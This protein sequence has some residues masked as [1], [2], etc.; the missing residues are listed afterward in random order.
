MRKFILAILMAVPVLL[1][2]THS[3]RAAATG[4]VTALTSNQANTV[5]AGAAVPIFKIN[6]NAS[7]GENLD[8]VGVALSSATSSTAA[9]ATSSFTALALYRD[10]AAPLGTFNPNDTLLG[11]TTVTSVTATTTL[12]LA[13]TTPATG[14]FFLVAITSNAWTDSGA[15]ETAGRVPQE[16]TANLD[17][18]TASGTPATLSGTLATQPFVADIHSQTP[19]VS[20]LGVN[21]NNSNQY[22]IFD[23]NGNGGVGEL[24]TLNVYA[25]SSPGAAPVATTSVGPGGHVSVNLG[26]TYYPSLWLDATDLAGNATSSQAQFTLPALPTVTSLKAFTDRIIFTASENL[27]GQQA[28]NCSNYSITQNGVTSTLSCGQPGSPFVNFM[29]NQVVIQGLNLTAGSSIGFS[30]SGIRDIASDQFAL[31]YATSSVTVLQAQTPTVSALSPNSGTAGVTS[32][33]I[34]GSNFGTST[35]SVLFSGGFDQNTGPLPPVAATSVTSW[36]DT[37]ITAVVPSGA[38]GGPVQIVTSDGMMSDPSQNTY[39]D[40]KGSIYL[41]LSLGTPS[42][43]IATST[44]MTFVMF[45]SSNNMHV[46]SDGNGATFDNSTKIYTIANV[47]SQGFVWAFDAGGADL[48]APGQPISPNTSTSSPQVLTLATS[49]P[50]SVSGTITLGGSSCANQYIGVMALPQGT[51][52]NAGGVQPAFF[53]TNGSCQATYSLALPDAGTY[54]V[55]THLPPQSTMTGVL[56]P[57]GQAITV[58]GGTPTATANF[59]FSTAA[60]SIYGKIVGADGQALPAAKYSNMMVYAYQPIK[61]GQGAVAQPDSNGYFRVYASTGAYKVTVGG[62][63]MPNGPET[64]VLVDSSASFAANAT[65]TVV[66]ITMAPPSSYIEGYVKDASGNGLASVDVFSYCS[67]GP[68]GGH[69][70][71]DNQG[72]YKMYVPPCANYHINGFSSTYGQLTEQSNIAIANGS[73]SATVNFTVN[74]SNFV[75]ISGQVLQNGSPA[76]GANVWITQGS[77]GQGLAGGQTDNSGNFSLKVMSGSANLYVHAAIMGSGQLGQA[78]ILDSGNSTITH[79]VSGISLSSNVATLTIHLVPGNTFD[80]VFLSAHSNNGGGYSTLI[81]TSTAYDVYQIQNLPYSGTTNYTL[82]G[83]IPGFGSIPS[84]T[85]AV[86]SS[87]PA[88]VTI[89]L[90]SINNFYTVSGT[91]SGDYTNGYVWASS[92]SDNTGV[93][94]QPN[95]TFSL[96]L[97]QGVYDIGVNKPGDTG[98]L[99][100]QQNIA[101]DTPGLSLSL[102]KNSST[103]SG[104]VA[105]NGTTISGVNVWADNGAGGWAGVETDTG[106]FSLSVTPGT[107]T[108]HAKADGYQL[109]APVIVTAPASGVSL[110]LSTVNFQSSTVSQTINPM[111]GGI[112]Q[113]GNETISIPPGALGQGTSVQ[114]TI[115]STM[116]TPDKTGAKVIG[117]GG[118]ISAGNITTLSS[119]ITLSFTLTPAQ[120][121]ADGITT[122]SAVNNIKLGYNDPTTNTWVNQPTTITLTPLTAAN[123]SDLTSVTVSAQTSHFSTYQSY[124]PTSGNA[125]AT[126]SGLA[127]TAGNSQVALS[128]SAV[129]GAA[130]YNIYRQ[131]GSNYVQIGQTSSTSYTDSSG[132]SNGTTYYYEVASVDSSGNNQS[133]PSSAVAAMPQAPASGGG[134]GGSVLVAATSCAS[135]TYSDYGACINGYQYRDIITRSPNSC[136]ITAAQYDTARRACTAGENNPTNNSNNS[137]SNTTGGSENKSGNNESSNS[138]EASV[139]AK[140]K[141]LVTKVSAALSRR[142]EGRILLQV[143]SHGEAWYVN[144]TNKLKYYLGRPADA[145]N[146]MRQLGLGVSNTDL[147][148]FSANRAPM[149]LAGRILLKVQSHGEAYYVNP[150]TKKLEYLGRPADALEIMRKD[151]LGITNSDIQEI[152][153]GELK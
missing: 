130:N 26:S 36:S 39:F 7:G 64:D 70:T 58:S 95:G 33:T 21:Y 152:D 153:V 9:L 131:S 148:E 107:W 142:L 90:S 43:I 85:V 11:T 108:L 76:V 136:S 20:K 53:Q 140:A 32:V 81:S 105:Y 66:T 120:L 12:T 46:Y 18:V 150:L 137:A 114:V 143:N 68:G 24:G 51:Q 106:S 54:T 42:Q 74:G 49:T 35:G 83:G 101:T 38:K 10:D 41:K 67:N 124:Q 104:T 127:A 97:Q 2:G 79:N 135:V 116:N 16:F 71:T 122:L 87:T 84:Q 88:T 110:N 111:Q 128:W 129:S 30:V 60:H 86:S 17:N 8:S 52:M 73:S 56:D 96:K 37:S 91:V 27:N 80:Q 40:I 55:Q 117:T 15:P 147:A 57:A 4:T 119:P 6:L 48:P 139:I 102:T 72:Y 146:A 144:P 1:F 138:S 126:P 65:S 145:F 134:G 151:G 77:Q 75:T 34:T 113:T 109:S 78:Q 61:G 28:N 99:L 133:S 115:T 149:R 31:S 132:L 112:I 14:D 125:P 63:D 25:T 89:D 44:N 3:A 59:T 47:S 50:Y 5:K 93:P 22:S 141:A 19:D 100:A 23:A 103:I 13:T 69:S 92:N 118:D 98:S 82:V 94:I 62:P 121:T 29:G 45:D 123:F